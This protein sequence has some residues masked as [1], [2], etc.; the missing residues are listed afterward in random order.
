[1]CMCAREAQFC[2]FKGHG[3]HL[4]KRTILY[5]LP[6]FVLIARKLFSLKIIVHFYTPVFLP[7]RIK[8]ASF[9]GWDFFKKEV[10]WP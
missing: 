5:S 10:N 3:E 6:S 1:M 8:F 9:S 2:F 4:T 7:D